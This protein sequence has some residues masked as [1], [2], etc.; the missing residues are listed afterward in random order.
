MLLQGLSGRGFQYCCVNITPRNYFV[1]GVLKSVWQ[2]LDRWAGILP[3]IFFQASMLQSVPETILQEVLS[4]L[5][6]G[7][8]IDRKKY[9]AKN[10]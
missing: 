7:L 6:V 5:P 4:P 8:V 2:D 9:L 10:D 1:G 3:T